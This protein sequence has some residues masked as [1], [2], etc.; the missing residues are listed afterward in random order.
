MEP[1]RYNRFILASVDVC[2]AKCELSYDISASLLTYTKEKDVLFRS[3]ESKKKKMQDLLRRIQFI[4][5][6]V[7]YRDGFL[8][9]SVWRDSL[10]LV[11]GDPRPAPVLQQ[12][13]NPLSLATT[14]VSITGA[15]IASSVDPSPPL[16]TTACSSKGVTSHK[17]VEDK[18]GLFV[19][20]Q[21]DERVNTTW[22]LWLYDEIGSVN[23][24]DATFFVH[25]DNQS[26]IINVQ[27]IDGNCVFLPGHDSRS[28]SACKGGKKE[29]SITTSSY[30]DTVH[31]YR[32]EA[33]L[34]V[35]SISI[36]TGVLADT[37]YPLHILA[38]R[39]T[40]FCDDE[41]SRQHPPL[42]ALEELL[43]S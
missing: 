24:N 28:C 13:V 43:S 4:E 6:A 39:H 23:T 14:P 9:A 1:F 32:L 31:H 7:Y 34:K 33:V 8:L 12:S 27:L 5:T 29:K 25:K 17:E 21:V 18:S 40:V 2:P 11:S 16:G 42:D 19:S 10:A 38:K 41:L 22:P 20:L 37:V 15:L 30:L 3:S 26:I 35:I 36:S